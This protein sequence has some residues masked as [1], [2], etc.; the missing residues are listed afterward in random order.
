MKMSK[1][2]VTPPAAEPAT[3]AEVKNYLRI[4]VSDDDSLITTM[5][6]A[7]TRRLED[8]LSMRFIT[9]VWDFWFDGFGPIGKGKDDWWDGTKQVAISTLT[10]Q[11]RICFPLGPCQSLDKFSTYGDDDQE[12]AA[13]LADYS[14]DKV[15]NQARLALKNGSVWPSTYL[16]P[17]NGV[18]V[19][20]TLGFGDATAIPY[21]IKQAVLELTGHM[22]ENRGDQDQMTI[23]AHILELVKP[24]V[25]VSLG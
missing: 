11:A 2:L 5:I 8:E 18:Q 17:I 3:L 4:D 20:M 25:V 24:W 16:R 22:Y 13:T 9:Q 7:A 12:I 1:K 15:S 6:K 19:R 21:E 23:P 14:V 10:Q